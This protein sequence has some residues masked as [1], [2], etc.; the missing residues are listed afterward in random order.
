MGS[1]HALIVSYL[2]LF[3][4]LGGSAA[5]LSGRHS[6]KPDDL[7]TGSVGE[8]AVR[9]GAIGRPELRTNSVFSRHLGTGVVHRRE[10]GI[11]SV[12]STA[13]RNRSVGSF[14]LGVQSQIDF[15]TSRIVG[16]LDGL[17]IVGDDVRISPA[18]DGFAPVEFTSVGGRGGSLHLDGSLAPS[19]GFLRFTETSQLPSPRSN[20]VSLFALDNGGTT[21]LVALLPTGTTV[22]LAP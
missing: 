14:D 11:A 13:I 1:R 12:T 5:A 21:E 3:V 6:V 18:E 10:L 7:A 20:S 8:R 17:R 16:G 19:S 4:A 2:A 15:P 9:H 22:Q